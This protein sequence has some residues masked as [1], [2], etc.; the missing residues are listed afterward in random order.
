[1]PKHQP[2][3]ALVTV[4]TFLFAA[5]FLPAPSSH[6]AANPALEGLEV[7]RRGFAGMQ[8]FTADISQEKHIA[9][10]KKRIVAKG[11]VRFKKPGSFYM[12]LF[13]PYASRLLL[14][15]G[16]IDIL[17]PAEGVRDRIVLPPEENLERWLTFL[18][19]P[20]TSLPE[21]VDV[22]AE[23]HGEQWTL[24]IFPRG[25][26][27]VREV[28]LAFAGDGRLK[29]LAIEERNRD[30][31]IIKFSHMRPNTGLTDRDFLLE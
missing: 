30:K 14:R 4:L 9:L 26:G 12:E 29:R 25:R 19:R 13:P 22:Q 23:R 3:L 31:T 27:S 1:M 28:Q 17:L 20:V 11:V 18:S 16:T 8:D 15:D 10:M 6:A 2:I 21:G 5:L 24:R 7:L